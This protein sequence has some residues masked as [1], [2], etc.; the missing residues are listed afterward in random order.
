MAILSPRPPTGR[1]YEIV[2]ADMAIGN[3]S[4]RA[5]MNESAREIVDLSRKMGKLFVVVDNS[6]LIYAVPTGSKRAQALE[7]GYPGGVVGVF[8]AE[9]ATS[10]LVEA[11]H[12]TANQL[13]GGTTWD[14]R[15]VGRP[16]GTPLR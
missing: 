14:R 12:I 6:G 16:S 4:T 7:D 15:R 8:S 11:I 2:T 1:R 13:A 5:T 10:D 3:S 9:A